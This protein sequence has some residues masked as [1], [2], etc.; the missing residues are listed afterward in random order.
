MSARRTVA[1]LAATYFNYRKTTIYGGSNEV[2]RNIVAQTVLGR[3]AP[4]RLPAPLREAPRRRPT[5][6]FEFT[7]EQISLRDAVQRWVEKGFSFERRH[8]LAK[9]GGATRAVYAELAELGLTGLAVP[10]RPRRPGL[11][12]GRGDGGDGRTR[13][14]PGQ[15][16]LC[17]GRAGRAGAAGAGRRRPCSPPGCRASPTGRPWSCSRSRNAAR[18]TAWT[19]SRRRR[20]GRRRLVAHRPQE[21]GAGRRRGR[22]LHRAGTASGRTPA[23]RLG[24]FLVERGRCAVRG[25]PTQDGAR[26]ADITLAA[27]PAQRVLADG[28]RALE[29]RSTSASPPPAPKASA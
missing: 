13:P 20:S 16:A 11:R 17:R 26:A 22:C 29:T 23:R 24:L 14:R 10:G 4:A 19:P 28:A 21:P 27:T 8:A 12:C 15:C 5:M 6:D 3:D 1:P 2:Q 18:A 9:A 7:D 25:Y